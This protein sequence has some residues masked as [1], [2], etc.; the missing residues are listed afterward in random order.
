MVKHKVD[1]DRVFGALADATRRSVLAQLAKKNKQPLSK[2]AESYSIS[3]PAVSKHITVLED[4]GIVRREKVGRTQLIS[5]N[6]KT[7]DAGLDWL[8]HHQAFWNAN[9]DRLERHL[10]TKK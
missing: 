8:M 2:L 5:V 1:L 4:A 3:L 9:F 7:L 6:P 10:T